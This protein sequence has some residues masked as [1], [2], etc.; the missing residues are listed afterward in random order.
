MGPREDEGGDLG[1]FKATGI[2]PRLIGNL[3]SH[4]EVTGE[5][6]HFL[7]CPIDLTS[8]LR[9]FHNISFR[10]LATT[11]G[12][13][14]VVLFTASYFHSLHRDYHKRVINTSTAK[15][16]VDQKIKTPFQV[17]PSRQFP[18]HVSQSGNLLEWLVGN[19]AD[20][21]S[22]PRHFLLSI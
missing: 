4:F 16:T 1:D 18:D 3:G 10:S 12:S 14:S 17:R 8:M 13:V 9:Y 11:T 20:Q 19:R 21:T 7:S 6:S 22:D 15:M 2:S 5:G